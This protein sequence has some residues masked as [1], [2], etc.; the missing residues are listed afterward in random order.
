MSRSVD[1]DSREYAERIA[2]ELRKRIEIAFRPDTAAQGLEG[3]VPSAG[4]CG[5]A[6]VVVQNILGGQLASA[7]VG[8]ISHWFNRVRF[9]EHTF[10]IDLTADQ[11]G[12]PAI[13]IA[14]ADQLYI[15]SRVRS[16]SDLKLETL[17]RAALLANRAGLRQTHAKLEHEIKVR[18]GLDYRGSGKTH[19]H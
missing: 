7:I 1:Q 9:G 2:R 14:E 6:S 8:G 3:N 15:G 17:L 10:D 11:F 12:G 4:H 18:A 13:V 19:N 16:Y 5:V